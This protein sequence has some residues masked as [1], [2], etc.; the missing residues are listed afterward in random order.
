MLKGADRL[1]RSLIPSLLG[2]R[3]VNESLSNTNIELF[4]TARIYLPE[5][6]GLPR[7]ELMLGITSG[8]GFLVLKG[9]IESLI[10]SIQPN[11]SL[12]IRRTSHDLL[13]S[14]YSAE[15][16]IGE[17]LVGFMGEVSAAGLKRFSLRSPATVAELRF[18]VLEQI[19]DLK[20]QH[21]SQSPYPSVS[22]DLNLVVEEKI[23]WSQIAETVRTAA[24]ELL[25]DIHFHE[26]YRAPDKDGP[27]KKRLL[28]SV[29]F[30]S[31]QRTLTG[32]EV[33]VC[34]ERI[35][36]ACRE[37]CGAGLIE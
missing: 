4:E 13:D 36:A 30:R 14:T 34:R 37:S 12:G 19:V 26:P 24:G 33:D 7:E 1:R 28:F 10:S 20:R 2:A 23:R 32:E 18:A 5:G 21:R 17:H 16:C 35:V 25:E 22:R 8:G 9:M 27:S 11:V 29:T 6:D 15:L 3:R 31:S